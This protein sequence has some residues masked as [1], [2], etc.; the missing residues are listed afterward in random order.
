MLMKC[1]LESTGV[2]GWL[3]VIASY[4]NY[5]IRGLE[6]S[7]PTSLTPH[8]ATCRKG[9]RLEIESMANDFIKHNLELSLHKNPKRM[10]SASLQVGEYMMI[11]RFE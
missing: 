2:G 8:P 6:F 1:L 3:P 4:S 7:A 11:W 5:V 9:E 10:G